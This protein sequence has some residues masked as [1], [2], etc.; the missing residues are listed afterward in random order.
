MESNFTDLERQLA[1]LLDSNAH[2]PS[3]EELR[4]RTVES[5]ARRHWPF[6]VS[7]GRITL[8]RAVVFAAVVV[9]L[10]VAATVGSL[11]VVGSSP[12]RHAR[13]T[14]PSRTVTPTSTS[15]TTTVPSTTSTTLFQESRYQQNVSLPV[16]Q[17][18][19]LQ[20]VD[21]TDGWLVMPYGNTGSAILATTN[22]GVTWRISYLTTYTNSV[23]GIDFLNAR[24]GWA[25]TAKH[26]L[27]TADGGET[28]QV[29]STG[30]QDGGFA[31]FD[32]VTPSD[33]WAIT[34]GDTLISTT[35]GGESWASVVTP[36]APAAICPASGSHLWMSGTN[37]AIYE[38]QDAGTQWR[39]VLPLS[40]VPPL[41][42]GKDGEYFESPALACSGHSAWALYAWT[43]GAGQQPSEIEATSDDGATWALL[44][45][46]KT[47]IEL[48]E[49]VSIN[50][51]STEDGWL[52]SGCSSC[53]SANIYSASTTDGGR[54]FIGSYPVTTPG[55]GVFEQGVSV[56]NGVDAWIFVGED[57]GMGGPTYDLVGS[58]NGGRTWRVVSGHLP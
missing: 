57:S 37:E 22:G 25:L 31:S 32:F 24:D 10:I 11:D 54:T 26:L 16:P 17:L 49:P 4:I 12:G 5:R 40:H 36:V 30:D 14:G 27:R 33:G 34:E 55:V 1:I 53:D 8:G 2:D 44:G 15:T 19:T 47:P 7:A 21:E 39:P 42:N 38:S 48:N 23:D 35:D 46:P 9:A 20:F 41:F 50:M 18:Q 28:W 56:L 58:V 13:P 51:T 45:S 29:L 43:P 3:I 6:A 52:W